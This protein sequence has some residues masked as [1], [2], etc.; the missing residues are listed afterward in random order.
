MNFSQVISVGSF[1]FLERGGGVGGGVQS[2][3]KFFLIKWVNLLPTICT[4]V[5]CD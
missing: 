3:I 1:F 4:N 2:A 5:T